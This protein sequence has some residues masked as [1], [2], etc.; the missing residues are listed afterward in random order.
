MT[1]RVVAVVGAGP[2]LGGSVAVRFAKD[3]YKV[4]LLTRTEKSVEPTVEKLKATGAKYLHV[5]CDASNKEQVDKAFS[6]IRKELGAVNVLVFNSGGG[7]LQKPILEVSGENLTSAFSDQV[8]AALYTSQACLPDMISAKEG[9]ILFTSATSAVRANA[10]NAPFSIAKHG[11][12][13]LANSIAREHGPQGVHSVH[14]RIDCAIDGP[15]AKAWMGDRYDVEALGNPDALAETYLWLSKQP[16][17][18]W[19]NEIDLRPAK[20]SWTC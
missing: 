13:A 10:K 5:A 19:T 4:A 9:T 8:L 3:G 7:F 18:G 14:V 12:K 15:K 6:A 1:S 11:L 17:V 16:K 2:G 20:E